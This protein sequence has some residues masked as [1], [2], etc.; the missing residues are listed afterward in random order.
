MKRKATRQEVIIHFGLL[1]KEVRIDDEG[2]IEFRDEETGG[3]WLDGR[4]LSEYF[5]CDRFGVYSH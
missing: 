4:Y 5:Y 3:E 2:H 1:G